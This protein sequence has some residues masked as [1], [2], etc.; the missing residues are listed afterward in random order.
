MGQLYPFT[1]PLS[2]QA[3]RVIVSGEGCWVTDE[4][5]NR[6]LDAV[7]G[8]WC[9]ALGWSDEE[10][11]E[12]A[13]DQMRR[14]PFYHSF[15]G[16]ASE[17]TERLAATLVP[18]LPGDLSHVFFG[19]SG[20]DAVETAVKVAQFYQN[21]RG[22]PRKKR[23]VARH[24]AYHGSGGV[25]FGL[26]GMSYVHGG[27]DRPEGA[28]IR[29]GRPHHYAE[30]RPNE[31]EGQ[32]ARRLADELDATLRAE[33]PDTVCAMIGEPIMGAGG[34]IIPP[35]GYWGAVQEVLR[36]HDVLLIADEVITGFG[37]TG[38]MFGCETYGIRPDMMTMAKQLTS[39]YA[40]LSATAVSREI[41]E[42]VGESAHGMGIFG[43]GFTYGGHPVSCA[44][45]LKAIEIYERMDLPA[46]VTR[47]GAHLASRL[48]GLR[49]RPGVGHVRSQGL[50]GA[51]EVTP[52]LA[53]RAGMEAEA[54]GVFF[55]IVDDSLCFS[56][57]LVVTE[58]E[59]D[60]FVAVLGDSVAAV[61]G[62]AA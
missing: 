44:V 11:V 39:A 42:V 9:V 19:T 21:A 30:A 25:S 50:I 29:C 53:A 32:F 60:H 40:P 24:G 27:F 35:E 15:K 51:V 55:R 28:V 54:R 47:L 34:V 2:G 22:K 33:D 56:P 4:A 49:G 31:S 37:R 20:S 17:P 61:V 62:E 1:D 41:H 6:F 23:I 12:A 3:P 7:A 36:A 26:T 45:A 16:R 59:I 13:A 14:L 57:P 43:H 52:G 8:L 46:H 18:M 48:D 38:R 5:G 58:E 10:L